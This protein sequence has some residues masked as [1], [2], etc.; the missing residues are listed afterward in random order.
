MNQ[1]QLRSGS[2]NA[3]SEGKVGPSGW[4]MGI[5]LAL[6]AAA[7]ITIAIYVSAPPAVS[8]PAANG[9]SNV[10]AHVETND[11]RA[12]DDPSFHAPQAA[13]Y[14]RLHDDPSFH[15]PQP[16]NKAQSVPS[17]ADQGVMNY[18]RAH[19]VGATSQSVPSAADQGVMNY[20]R[21]HSAGM[22][23]QS[24][25]SAADQGVMNYLRAHGAGQAEPSAM[26]YLHVPNSVRADPVPTALSLWDYRAHG[27]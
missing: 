27:K 3:R 5:G 2:K 6:A 22:T 17:A 13:S 25:P 9:A 16:S 15:A 10:V 7:A 24:V 14:G 19:G 11:Q 12:H 4:L 20:L 21:A 8:S 1:Q 26:D 23:S 18:L